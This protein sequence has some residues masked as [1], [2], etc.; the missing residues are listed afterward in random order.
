M[1]QRFE[2]LQKGDSQFYERFAHLGEVPD[3]SSSNDIT[4]DES[5]NN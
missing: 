5:E 1:H 2:R 3:N 4:N